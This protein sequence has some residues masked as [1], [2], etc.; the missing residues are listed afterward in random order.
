MP[1]TKSAKKAIRNSSKKRGFNLA[2]KEAMKTAVKKMKKLIAENKTDEAKKFF[3]TVQKI[4]D[5]ATKRG[6]VLKK[7]NAA[8]KKSRL[9]AALKKATA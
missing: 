8:R 2:R 7:N 6:G 5:K 3:P 9:I 4:I 1:I